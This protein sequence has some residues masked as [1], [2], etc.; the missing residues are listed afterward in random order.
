M[1]LVR[2][3]CAII[4]LICFVFSCLS[5]P[6]RAEETSP[7]E[8]ATDV[9]FSLTAEGTPAPGHTL[10][11][12][13]DPALE[14]VIYA[15]RWNP[16]EP[17]IILESNTYHIP[18][19]V[20]DASILYV[21]AWWEELLPLS[22]LELTIQAD[23]PEPT[24]PPEESTPSETEP[25]ESTPPETEPE[26]APLGPGLYFGQL[27]GHTAIS[28]GTGTIEEAFLY[29]ANVPGLDFFALTDHS[30]TFDGTEYWAAG[31]AA[32]DAVTGSSFVGMFGYEM[33]W[34]SQ[35]KLGH[36]ATFHTEDFISRDTPPFDQQSVA[37]D[38]Y[39]AAVA[40]REGSV[41]Q[42]NHPGEPYGNFEDFAYREAGDAAISLM[43]VGSGGA[44]RVDAYLRALDNGWHLAPT[45]NHPH[46]EGQW[47]EASAGRTV[48]YAQTLTEEGLCEAM[49]QHRV[50]ATQDSDLEILYSL[51]GHFMGAEVSRRQIG[52][53]ATVSVA[54][55]D[56]TDSAVGT[57][58]VI[59][60]GGMILASETVTECW[61]NLTFSLPGDHPYY[62]LRITQPDG[63]TAITAPVWVRQQENIGIRNFRSDTEVPVQNQP[64]TL[65][66]ELYNQESAPFLIDSIQIHAGDRLLAEDDALSQLPSG[67][68]LTH[69]IAISADLIGTE[70]ITAVLVGTLED[71]PREYTA[72]ITL[73]FRR[74]QDVQNILLAG[75]GEALSRFRKAAADNGL[76]LSDAVTPEALKTCRLLLVTAPETDF[77]PEL[78]DAIREFMDYGGS[79][80]VFGCAVSDDNARLNELLH[81]IGAAGRLGAILPDDT[82]P[83]DFQIN[84]EDPFCAGV[85]PDQRYRMDDG[86]SVEPGL[87]QWLVA[88]S[89]AGTVVLS[90][91]DTPAGGQIY[92]AGNR[93]M[94]DRYFTEPHAIWAPVPANRTLGLALLGM[95][96]DPVPISTIRQV[97]EAQPGQ[98]QK[99]RG[100]VTA[101]TDNPNT[102]FPDTLYLQDETGG[103]AVIPFTESGIAIGT[104]MEITGYPERSGNLTILNPVS[105]RIL[106]FAH[107]LY[108]PRKGNWS[109]LTDYDRNGSLLISVEGTCSEIGLGA[110][111]TLQTFT[112]ES[113]T[114]DIV[115]VQIDST[116]FS[117]STGMNTL[118]KKVRE[119]HT[120]RA[121]GLLHLLPEG[122]P[123]IRVRNCD[124]VVYVPPLEE[125]PKTADRIGYPV[126]AMAASLY[127][128]QKR[129][130]RRK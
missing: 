9:S 42:F 121:T 78:L 53:T 86:C 98:L 73:S 114:G 31:K 88:D 66:L 1:N 65:A 26:D 32:A 123:V 125:I 92:I 57:V 64:I 55:L 24:N 50:Y 109:E 58:E 6:C 27:H 28:G 75:S 70:S 20:A 89:A 102:R 85:A 47:G 56:P 51:N 61:A 83:A 105:H 39:Y 49:N 111:G 84:R 116:V 112:L 127:V 99:I 122:T 97:R 118:H 113:A 67:G 54:L 93:F 120:I 87:G 35:K 4:L 59:T 29:A 107:Y 34:Q 15:V 96:S 14:G 30:H 16:A 63:D 10:T 45:N 33:N 17:F 103:I 18:E 68:T 52:E 3:N 129:R 104:P 82:P 110:D 12:G 94:E 46:Y 48:V 77:S 106:D 41:S 128:L 101:G 44:I 72:R 119:G 13:T 74:S 76:A 60:T 11:F 69:R 100:Y 36:I 62:L 40:S 90:R 22:G 80:A 126:C 81:I 37:L 25:E 91:E 95:A 117:G 130:S 38:S 7:P 43:E 124:E 23:S 8:T 115:R 108:P 5:L 19:D 71:Q 21:T 79:I 2:R